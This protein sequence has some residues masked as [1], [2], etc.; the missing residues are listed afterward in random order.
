MMQ[1]DSGLREVTDSCPLNNP[2]TEIFL[3]NG[4][5]DQHSAVDSADALLITQCQN[6]FAN[7]FCPTNSEV[8][9]ENVFENIAFDELMNSNFANGIYRVG[10]PDEFTW[11]SSSPI[12]FAPKFNIFD[13]RTL[14]SDDGFGISG[15]GSLSI[16]FKTPLSGISFAIAGFD[17][18]ENP[19]VKDSMDIRVYKADGTSLNVN[20]YIAYL[21]GNVLYESPNTYSAIEFS[22]I[23]PE[24]VR[25][26]ISF[27]FG[28]LQIDKI[29][30]DYD[31]RVN[32][33]SSLFLAEPKRNLAPIQSSLAPVENDVVGQTLTFNVPYNQVEPNT[34]FDIPIYIDD[35]SSSVGSVTFK[36]AY[37]ENV[38]RVNQCSLVELDG[39]CNAD[40]PGEAVIS[41]IDFL[42]ESGLVTVVNLNVTAIGAAGTM[43]PLSII[44]LSTL[45]TVAGQPIDSP[46]TENGLIQISAPEAP[47]AVSFETSSIDNR[48]LIVSILALLGLSALLFYIA[49]WWVLRGWRK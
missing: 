3:G 39:I 16:D 18:Q 26:Q 2:K 30:I 23:G 19:L 29:E 46:S 25:G 8:I 27:D 13:G 43:S 17:T 12:N 38:I 22:A 21:G 36:F 9:T 15:Q 40:T 42:G 7:E 34:T 47:T 48:T 33:N 32:G 20:D 49:Q 11:T 37:D 5:I 35:I 10:H 1:Y 28:L 45:S 31:T 4:E 6:G 44:D 14:G 41:G 24:D